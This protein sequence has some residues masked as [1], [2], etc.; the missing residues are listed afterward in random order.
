MTPLTLPLATSDDTTPE[1]LAKMLESGSIV[2]KKPLK[3]SASTLRAMLAMKLAYE[4]AKAENARWGLPMI[5][6]DWTPEDWERIRQK[7][8]KKA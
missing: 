1:E 3:L 4:D 2:R 5:P 8:A 7:H 6:Q